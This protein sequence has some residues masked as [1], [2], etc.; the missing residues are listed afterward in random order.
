MYRYGVQVALEDLP[1]RMPIVLRGAN[2]QAVSADAKKAGYDAMELYIYNPAQ[3]DAKEFAKVAADNG[4]TYSGIC[5][6][7]EKIINELCLTDED[8]SVRQK[9]VDRLKEHLDFGT[10]I[11]CPVVVGTMRGNI[12]TWDQRQV[13]LD[14]LADAMGQLNAYAEEVGGELLVENILQYVSNYLN[15]LDE[16]GGFIKGLGLSRVK[17]HID[18]HSMHMEETHPYDA[19]RKYGDILGYVHFSDSNRGY[20]GSGMIDFKS[21]FHALMDVNYQGYIVAEYQPYPSAMES[22]V[23]G[24]KY[25]KLMEQAAEIERLPFKL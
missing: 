13:Y 22:A 23:R 6:G 3:Y 1:E 19:V 9:A 5:T 25:M 18:T 21:Y 14:R 4:L 2:I 20:P 12:S 7:L 24:L 8:A 17:L 15:S 10:A 16:V 11:G